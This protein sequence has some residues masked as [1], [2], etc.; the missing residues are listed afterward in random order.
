MPEPTNAEKEAAKGRRP[1]RPPKRS[2]VKSSAILPNTG[3]ESDHK[4]SPRVSGYLI[5]KYLSVFFHF[6]GNGLGHPSSLL[7][8]SDMFPD[9]SFCH[10]TKATFSQVRVGNCKLF[11]LTL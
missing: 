3:D 5:W 10:P 7:W 11:N 1:G 4:E 2:T 9:I 6:P 8:C